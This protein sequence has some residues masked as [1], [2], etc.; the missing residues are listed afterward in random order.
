VAEERFA[1]YAEMYQWPL[2]AALLLLFVE[3]FIPVRARRG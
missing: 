2:A 1:D 3:A